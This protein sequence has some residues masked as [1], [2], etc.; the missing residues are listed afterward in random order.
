MSDHFA[1]P[2]APSLANE[3][4]DAATQP[5]AAE[6]L[7][8]VGESGR[9]DVMSAPA[10]PPNPLGP[11][12]PLR[13]VMHP[14]TR[15]RWA[16]WIAWWLILLA[17]F[18]AVPGVWRI[19]EGF[20]E[21]G[22]EITPRW[23]YLSLLSSLVLL[24]SA[25]LAMLLPDWSTALGAAVT[26][27]LVTAAHAM[28]LGVTVSGSTDN[29]LIQALE[30]DDFTPTRQAARWCFVMVCLGLL[31]TFFTGRLAARWRSIGLSESRGGEAS[32]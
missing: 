18:S 15:R 20:R 22:P 5:R 30:L 23:T 9:L 19:A 29:P 16:H 26:L 21:D 4:N 7:T 28:M 3:L 31:L 14:W 6:R 32:A 1:T 2:L 13:G 17:V 12:E 11:G 8:G 10:E 25:S 24:G 27:L